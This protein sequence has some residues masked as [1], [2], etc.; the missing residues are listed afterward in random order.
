[1]SVHDQLL[2]IQQETENSSAKKNHLPTDSLDGI[3]KMLPEKK[4]KKTQR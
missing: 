1:M 4:G 2:L 3:N